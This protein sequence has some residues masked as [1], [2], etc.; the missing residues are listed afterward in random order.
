MY[1]TRQTFQGDL[2]ALVARET[3]RITARGGQVTRSYP[4]NLT[5]VA[6]EVRPVG[7]SFFARVGGC[8]HFQ[9]MVVH[10]GQAYIFHGE[11]E[12][13]GSAFAIVGAFMYVRATSFHVDPPS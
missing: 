9:L 8:F 7:H 2:P 10:K 13:S 4:G 6:G 11:T 3:A 5:K 12:D 1:A